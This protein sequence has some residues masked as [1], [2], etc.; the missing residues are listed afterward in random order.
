MYAA[1]NVYEGKKKFNNSG[2]VDHS[3]LSC[4]VS[5]F[6]IKPSIP[7]RNCVI[8]SLETRHSVFLEK[9]DSKASIDSFS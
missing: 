1:E 3:F 6:G 2:G 7:G 4:Q 8:S 9:T 5:T